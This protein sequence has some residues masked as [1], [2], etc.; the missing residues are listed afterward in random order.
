M[1]VR[2]YVLKCVGY[3]NCGSFDNC[4]GVLVICVLVFI[5]FLYCFIYVYL[6]LFVSSVRTTV[7]EEDPSEVNNNNNY[8]Y[9]EE[10]GANFF[11]TFRKNNSTSNVLTNFQGNK[12]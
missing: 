6:F 4:V 3:V 5:A 10:I 8:Y 9:Y 1:G 12:I 11:P 7:T 2:T